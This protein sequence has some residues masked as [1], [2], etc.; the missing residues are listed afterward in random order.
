MV[1]RICQYCS[2]E[3][4][5]NTWRLK[6]QKRGKYCSVPC[7]RKFHSGDKSIYWC[8]RLK[9][10]DNPNWKGD[11]VGYIGL[12]TW[13]KNQLGK[14]NVCTHCHS[15]IKKRYEWANKSGKYERNIDDWL[16][17]C[18]SCHRKYDYE[19]RITYVCA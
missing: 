12:H 2:K 4:K 1:I 18:T 3:F 7:Q 14:P 19:R 16:R 5:I 17:L 13:V 9:G 11:K 6:D 10:E 15:T 8:R